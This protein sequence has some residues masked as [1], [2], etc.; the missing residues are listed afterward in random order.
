MRDNQMKIY[1]VL[2]T[3]KATN[4]V[5]DHYLI[6]VMESELAQIEKNIHAKYPHNILLV[7]FIEK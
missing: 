1:K 2:I 3:N 4:K 6:K 7:K 5:F